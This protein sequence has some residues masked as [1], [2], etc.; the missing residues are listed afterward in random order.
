MLQK[1]ILS[2]I[3]S[4]AYPK[5]IM[6]FKYTVPALPSEY[7]TAFQNADIR[8]EYE[9]EINEGLAFR[10]AYAFVTEFKLKKIAVGYDMRLSTPTLREAFII[11]ARFAGADV[12]DI[13]LVTTPMLY[14]VSGS[15]DMYGVMITASHSPKN[16]NGFKLV[17]SGA[18]PLTNTTGLNAIKKSLKAV[19]SEVV[20]ITGKLQKKNVFKAYEKYIQTYISYKP[21]SAIKVVA[22]AGNGMATILAP[23]LTNYKKVSV[24]KLFFTLD[25]SFPNHASNPTIAKNQKEIIKKLKTGQYDFGFSFDG[26]ADRVAFFDEKGNYI[27]AAIIGA[28]LAKDFL[29]TD[30]KRKFVHTVLT[31]SMYLETIVAMGGK[32]TIARVGH[33]FIKQEMRKQKAYFSCEH[34][35]HFF[36]QDYFYADSV[37]LTVLHV[38]RIYELARKNGQTFSQ[39]IK[40]LNTYFQT[41]DFM[42]DVEDKESV[43]KVLTNWFADKKPDSL[44]HYDG[45][46]AI[47]GTTKVVA[48]P[49]VTENAINVMAE[50]V[51]KKDALALRKEV[52]DFIHTVLN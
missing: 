38:M 30:K 2:K 18:V 34:S 42:I 48:K 23:L 8:G 21:T 51:H 1:I 10:I 36:Y 43:M 46:T 9:S 44:N 40:P 3:F 25:G 37:M 47:F 13:G 5:L 31:N 29:A 35:A 49:S 19:P 11:G 33:S 6:K 39:M 28:L 22:D 41:E 4:Q 17:K 52:V 27:N 24:E 7:T 20:E 45:L 15:M 16:Y 12:L 50:S 32:S 14:F 26:D